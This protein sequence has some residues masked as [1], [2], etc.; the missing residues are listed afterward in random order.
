MEGKWQGRKEEEISKS[1]VDKKL[2]A[3]ELSRW[4]LESS[5]ETKMVQW[6]RKWTFSWNM[7]N[8]GT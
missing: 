6:G 3:I 4:R 7:P 8:V 1:N 2:I 5:S